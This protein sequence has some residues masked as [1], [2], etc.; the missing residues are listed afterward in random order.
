MKED[1][2]RIVFVLPGLAAPPS[3]NPG[4]MGSKAFGLLQLARLVLP[5]PPAFVLGTS[6]CREYFASKNRLSQDIPELLTAGLARLEEATGRKFGS[7]ELAP[8]EDR[9]PPR[10]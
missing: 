9:A 4:T 6:L 2:D 7:G 1:N 10:I 3:A 5:V 8:G